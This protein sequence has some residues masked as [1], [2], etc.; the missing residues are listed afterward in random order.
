MNINLSKEKSTVVATVEFN[1]QEWVNAQ[2]KAYARLAQ[3]VT[4]AGF[5][6]GKAPLDLAKKQIDGRKMIEK[7][8]DILV[9]EGNEA[10]LKE[11]NL[12]LLVRPTVDIKDVADDKVVI[13]YT[14]VVRPEVKLGAYKDIEI[15]KDSVEVTE[16]DIENELKALQQKNVEIK[17]KEG[18]IELGNTAN[19]DFKGFVNNVAFEGGEAKGYDLEIGSGSFIPGFEDQLVGHS[20]GESFDINVTFP[21]QYSKELAGKAAVFKIKINSVSEKVMPEINDD[22]ALDANIEGVGN[23]EELK[24]HLNKQVA[25]RKEQEADQKAFGQLLDTIVNGSEVEVPEA[26]I[27]ED[28]NNQLNNFKQN[29]EQRGIPY[30]KYLEISGQSEES[31]LENMKVEAERNLRASFVFQEIAKVENIQV[32]NEDIENEFQKI[33]AQYNMEYNKVKEALSPRVNELANNIYQTKL[34]TLLRSANKIA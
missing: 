22:L 30:D 17:V 6:K 13:E 33:A 28:A 20:A 10:V 11:N 25:T 12:E 16:E 2:E 23:L 26:V 34:T 27:V 4:V 31:I 8:V 32:T 9:P 19:I 7:A 14:Y 21:E 24:A 5:R 3:N 1:Q 29:V 15:A 18:A